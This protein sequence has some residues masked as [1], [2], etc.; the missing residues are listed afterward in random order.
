MW[1]QYIAQAKWIAQNFPKDK[2]YENI[3]IHNGDS[4]NVLKASYMQYVSKPCLSY[5]MAH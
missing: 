2:R 4:G 5:M 3:I 1:S